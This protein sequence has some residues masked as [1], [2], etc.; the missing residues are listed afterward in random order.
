MSLSD[1]CEFFRDTQMRI[2]CR[3]EPDDSVA[4]GGGGVRRAGTGEGTRAGEVGSVNAG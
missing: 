1:V 2:G 3:C 4:R